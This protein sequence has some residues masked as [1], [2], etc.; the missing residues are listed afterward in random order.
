MGML[1]LMGSD[2]VFH[3]PGAQSDQGQTDN[4]LPDFII[5]D[6]DAFANIHADGRARFA[7]RKIQNI[8]SSS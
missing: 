2:Q 7:Y 8:A 5:A 6:D 4:F 1:V 3:H